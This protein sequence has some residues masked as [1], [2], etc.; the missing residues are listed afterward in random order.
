M[1]YPAEDYTSK[2]VE[3]ADALKASNHRHLFNAIVLKAMTTRGRKS[4]MM[5]MERMTGGR[6]L[7]IS[8][9]VLT[10]KLSIR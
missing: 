5:V 8:A 2:V 1:H 3:V 6:M 7:S 9:S 10:I 4:I